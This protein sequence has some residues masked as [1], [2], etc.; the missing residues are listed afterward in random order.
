MPYTHY[1]KLEEN[2]IFALHW[3]RPPVM[4]NFLNHPPFDSLNRIHEPLAPGQVI[5]LCHAAN[6]FTKFLGTIACDQKLEV[7]FM[8]S[9]DEVA[10][11]GHW[12]TDETMPKLHYDG[13]SLRMAYDPAKQGPTGKFLVTILGRW[14]RVEIKH[15]GDKPT[16]FL[17]AYVRG[18]VF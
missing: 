18:S 13:E 1:P 11:D 9:N 17:R 6:N 10:E 7:T 12:V 5:T 14:L 8:F 4:P 3:P 15:V 2:C 16:E